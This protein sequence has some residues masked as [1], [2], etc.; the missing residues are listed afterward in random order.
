MEEFENEEKKAEQVETSE[1][2]ETTETNEVA[3]PEI[4]PQSDGLDEFEYSPV[5]P[6][7]P[8]N[9]KGLKIFALVLAA[10]ILLTGACSVGY[11]LGRKNI[12]SSGNKHTEAELAQKPANTDEMT[13]AQVYE[14]VNKSIVGIRIY[15]SKGAFTDASGVVY[16][17]EGYIVSNDHIYANFGAPKF[18]VYTYDGKEYNAEYIAGDK[19]SDLC[20]LKV[21]G[22]DLT[23]AEFG[24]SSNLFCGEHV[25][26]IGRPSDAADDTSI[27]SG[28]ITLPRRRVKND[29]S[30]TV[31][32]IQ[33][34]AA[35]NPGSSGGALVNMYGQVIGITSSKMST[36]QYEL[37]GFAM[38][39]VMMKRM[40][41]DM[42]K[43]GK[44]T[45]RAKLGITYTEVTSIYVEV[46]ECESKGLL[47]ASVSNDSD[48]YGKVTEGDIITHVNGLE[49]TR[50][51]VILNVIE[52]CK[53]GDTITLTVLS[54]GISKDYSVKLLANSGE[55]SYS[56][57]ENDSSSESEDSQNPGGG[58]FDFP[59]VD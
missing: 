15:N 59:F 28:I 26:A 40:V 25:V 1:T 53:A 34:D 32:Y 43:N 31:S 17:K 45:E 24:D 7:N 39:T 48:L 8:E 10:I 11:F 44:V 30:Y 38:P 55:S 47:I 41:E 6:S 49:I 57:V 21:S 23:P 3:E 46:G 33:T 22:A 54:K 18:K 4:M 9:R 20:I 19:V 36:D 2:T 14:K 52:D 16:S 29:S 51:D 13:A 27:T 35:I 58:T 56:E 12:I 37:V 5:E 42:L 50:D